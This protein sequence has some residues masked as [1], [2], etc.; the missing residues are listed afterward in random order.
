MEFPSACCRRCGKNP[1][2]LEEREAITDIL[3]FNNPATG[4]TV[5]HHVAVADGLA[6]CQSTIKRRMREVDGAGAGHG[7]ECRERISLCDNLLIV[8]RTP[9]FH[10]RPG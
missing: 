4:R 10:A 1:E 2:L 8:H 5:H 6:T 3:H 9:T 7:R